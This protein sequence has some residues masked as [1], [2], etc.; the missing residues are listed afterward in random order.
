VRE[1]LGEDEQR[2]S[3]QAAGV[4]TEVLIQRLARGARQRV[5]CVERPDG[6]RQPR[7]QREEHRPPDGAETLARHQ[8]NL[9]QGTKR[10]VIANQ[11]K[12]EFRVV[13]RRWFV[14]AQGRAAES[15]RSTVIEF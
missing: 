11:R 12:L 5:S 7:E 13:A 3:D 14:V 2:N 15:A 1:P 10:K 8:P 9:A 6:N 4:H